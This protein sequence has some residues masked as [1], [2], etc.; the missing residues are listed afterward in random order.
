MKNLLRK[1]ES[2][3]LLRRVL[4]DRAERNTVSGR[5]KRTALLGTAAF[6]ILFLFP[7]FG[8]AQTSAR[9][10]ESS[11]KTV[12]IVPTSHYDFGFVDPPDAVRERAVTPRGG[13]R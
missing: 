7:Q 8:L 6:F 11:I 4:D 12:Y 13:P 9:V 1:R 5:H 3:P 2:G 10:P